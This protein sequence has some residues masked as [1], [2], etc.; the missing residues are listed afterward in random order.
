MQFF[1]FVDGVI[2]LARPEIALYPNVN[3]ILKRDKGGKVTGDPD[4]RKKAYAF[5]ELTYVYFTCDFH[6]YPSQHA[7]SKEEAHFYAIQHSGLPEQY[8]PDSVVRDLMLQYLDEHLT[9]GKKTIKNLLDTF[10]LNDIAIA[11]INA[12]MKLLL[13]NSALTKDQISEMIK[14]QQDLMKIATEVPQQVKKLREALS[15]IQDEE[16]EILIR[17]GGEEVDQSMIPDNDIER[18]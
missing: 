17:R 15:L 10:S 4:G 8:E 1:K 18:D 14:Y 7:L 3:E 16:R 9:L 11:S 12:N 6:A 5:K 2:E 13:K